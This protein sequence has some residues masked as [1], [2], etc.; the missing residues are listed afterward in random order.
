MVA[1]PFALRCGSA[2]DVDWGA[3]TPVGAMPPFMFGTVDE[4]EDTEVPATVDGGTVGLDNPPVCDLFAGVE[5]AEFFPD[6][7][8]A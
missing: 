7:A 8:A 5:L 2:T 4:A 3:E 1:S 6:A